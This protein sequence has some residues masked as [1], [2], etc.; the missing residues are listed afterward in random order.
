MGSEIWALVGVVV[1][2]L[3]AGVLQI[4]AGVLQRKHDREAG[5][6]QR[7]HDRIT[8]MAGKRYDTYMRI[9]EDAARS[10]LAASDLFGLMARSHDLAEEVARRRA[11]NDMQSECMTRYEMHWVLSSKRVRDALFELTLAAPGIRCEH[12]DGSWNGE[13]AAEQLRAFIEVIA[14]LVMAVTDD[15]Q[16]DEL[17]PS[18]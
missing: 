2:A 15:L 4:I 1:G 9:L 14:R 11:F 5:V 8:D 18:G 16:V 7:Q 17:L 6:L 12:P 10:K 3:I 13:L